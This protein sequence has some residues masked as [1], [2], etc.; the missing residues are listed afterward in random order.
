MQHKKTDK[1]IPL[2]K[3]L[4]GLGNE[5]AGGGMGLRIVTVQTTEPDTITLVMEGTDLAL[6]LDIFEVPVDFYPLRV[7][8]QLLAFPLVNHDG[9]GRWGAVA[10]ITGGVVMGTMQSATSCQPDWM[11]I[12]Y[13]VDRLIIPPYFAVN[14][15]VNQST[16]DLVAADIRPLQAGDRVS[17]APTWDGSQIK[18]VILNR[19]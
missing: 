3:L 13:G 14:N 18:Y 11:A 19:Y 9:S 2:L 4:A 16:G 5:A 1:M 8:D 17:I 15:A 7:G 10:K 12:T 6:D